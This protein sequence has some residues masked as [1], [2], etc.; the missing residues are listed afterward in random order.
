MHLRERAQRRRTPS[1]ASGETRDPNRAAAFSSLAELLEEDPELVRPS[2]RETLGAFVVGPVSSL[3]VGE[4][5]GPRALVLLGD[6]GAGAETTSVTHLRLLEA[7][8]VAVVRDAWDMAAEV[9]DVLIRS[10]TSVGELAEVVG[11]DV[12]EIEAAL[13]G[14][15]PGDDYFTRRPVLDEGERRRWITDLGTSVGA[16]APA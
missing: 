14:Q 13:A 16:D 15:D 5:L 4:V 12:W 6:Y 8:A 1:L 7:L 3:D 10:G 11:L 9:G 2:T